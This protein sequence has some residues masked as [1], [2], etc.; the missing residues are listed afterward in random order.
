MSRMH[1]VVVGNSIAGMEAALALRARAPDAR[2]TVVSAESR[3][4]FARTALMYVF[5]GQL[6]L[7]DTEFHERDVYVRHRL[8]RVHDRVVRVDVAARR[9]ELA[10]GSALAYDR[11]LLAVG[12]RPRRLPFPEAYAGPGVHHF[13]GL[14]DLRA[15]DAAARPG[16]RA[17]VIGGGL[18]GVELAEVLH[19]RGLPTHWLVRE[20]WT[21]PVALDRAE[22][23][24][25]ERHVLAHGVHVRT[26]CAVRGL[27]RGPSGITLDV[28]GGP[29]EVDLVVGAI[30]V[31]PNTE[32]LAGSGVALAAS[33]AIETD[34]SLAVP[35][36]PG[37][38]AAGDC[39]N[40]T[41]LDGARRPETLWYT[42]RDQGRLAAASMLGDPVEYR[43][44]CWINS[45]KFFDLEYT[46]AG[47]VP[48]AE[49]TR[50]NPTPGRWQTWFQV[51]PTEAA[52]L[53]ILL[54]DE[55][56]VGFNALGRRFDTSVWLR[57]IQQ[58]RPLSHV[59]AHLGESSF[60]EE[61]MA[62]F[63]VDPRTPL[64]EGA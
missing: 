3:H 13:V 60:D 7:E 35:S 34:A 20:P 25:V 59:L 57:W 5:A 58:K 31:E 22:A 45:A 26:D 50:R 49:A 1:H 55:R 42:A 19:A 40:V 37:V 28:P 46:T 36:A 51:H 33:G 56:V 62:P 18:I 4:P 32:F 8:D 21:W 12:S 38:W 24:V 30:G 2:I 15:L 39:A 23:A 54:K 47:Y 52:S 43:R 27:A 53:R 64:L 63:P 41:W 17:A 29:L 44:T 48:L 6:R 14:D 61:F 9:L 16:M 11:L 10:S